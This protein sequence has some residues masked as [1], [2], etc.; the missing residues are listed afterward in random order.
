MGRVMPTEIDDYFLLDV[1]LI[2]LLINY[3][4]PLSTIYSIMLLVGSLM[5]LVPISFNLFRWIP[6]SKPG[7]KFEKYAIGAVFGF[8]FLYVYNLITVTPMSTVFATTVFGESKMLTVLVYSLLIPK[9]ET[10][11]FFVTCLQWWAWKAGDSVHVSP[12]S[13][14]GVKLMLMFGAVFTLFHATAKG[15]LNTP[16][17]IATAAF[18]VLSVAMILYFQ[19]Y[20]QAVVMHI[21][22]NAKAMGLFDT[23]QMLVT[24]AGMW[25][26]IGIAGILLYWIKVGHKAR[27]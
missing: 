4:M 23:I 5:Y 14:T 20:I 12:F 26:F 18:G 17:L 8:V 7:N 10:V 27:F 15:V 24:Q 22:V 1:V 21:V 19:E 11:F 25:I 13:L 3:N 16:D 2:F 9:V 6:S